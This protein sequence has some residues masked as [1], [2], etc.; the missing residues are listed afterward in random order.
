VS[1]RDYL[2]SD[3][4]FYRRVAIGF[5]R[6]ALQRRCVVGEPGKQ[7]RLL[8]RHGT[9]SAYEG[10][11][12]FSA[13]RPSRPAGRRV[14]GLAGAPPQRFDRISRSQSYRLLQH[15]LTHARQFDMLRR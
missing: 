10:A 14:L 1:T 3:C 9:S 2:C 13:R 11:L 12:P 6:R 5:E 15:L 4:G 8:R 7:Q